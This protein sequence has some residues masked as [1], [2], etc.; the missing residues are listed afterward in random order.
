MYS[1][2][3]PLE[4]LRKLY[5]KVVLADI[6]TALTAAVMLLLLM[7]TK[8]ELASPAQIALTIA[9]AAVLAVIEYAVER[10]LRKRGLNAALV[11]FLCL[12]GTLIIGG[13]LL[14][15]SLPGLM[16]FFCFRPL[17]PLFSLLRDRGRLT[18]GRPCET[19]GRVKKGSQREASGMDTFLLFE[20]ELTHES[21]L[22]RAAG[23]SP[24][25]RYRVL[26]LPHSGLAVGE[27]IPDELSFDPFGNPIDTG[28]TPA[29]PATEAAEAPPPG[30]RRRIDPNSHDRQRAARYAVCGRVCHIVS[31]LLFV[32]TFVGAIAAQGDGNSAPA[33]FVL[34]ILPLLACVLLGSFFKSQ[35]LKLR[36][37]ERTTAI[38]VDTVRRRSGKH[39]HRYP[40]VEFEVDGVTYTAELTVSCSRDA[41]GQL[42]SFY[43]DPLEPT[44][45]RGGW[46]E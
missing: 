19:V 28:Y 13:L 36:C 39:S 46:R 29:E 22:L 20:D 11:S 5:R 45:V 16:G 42:Y 9:V 18:E 10:T 4:G 2:I 21:H 12:I 3:P 34:A 25:H 15:A 44:V 17:I 30:A 26:F 33:V 14:G 32:L 40:I 27:A 1:P 43:Y 23:L 35:E 6:G 8:T 31:I 7:I 41:V 38:C 37:T 24:R